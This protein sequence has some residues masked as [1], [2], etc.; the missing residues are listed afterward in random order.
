MSPKDF[1]SDRKRSRPMEKHGIT[2]VLKKNKLALSLLI[3][4][5]LVLVI[6]SVYFVFIEMNKE[7]DE[8]NNDGNSGDYGSSY[9]VAV[10]QTNMG[11]IKI[12][13]YPDKVNI[14]ANN[15]ITH[16]KNGYYDGLTFHRVI[17]DF[18]IQ[19]GDPNGD[20]TGGYAAEY[21]EGYGDPDQQSTWVIP[22]EF[23]ED[24]KNER[25][26]ISMANRGEN[27]GGS[28]FFILV[29]DSPHLDNKHAVFGKIIE[30]MDVVDAISEVDTDS[31]DKPKNPVVIS[32][33][34]IIE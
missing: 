28:Q 21:H 30:G 24:L 31:N 23:D 4:I 25:G 10:M 17:P 14:T 32:S 8:N 13:L 1:S 9:P 26:M 15:F 34:T 6:A 20:G 19:G 5:V 27:T 22:D 11:T 16:A 2:F 3:L 18:M 33:I 12:E 7:E 29:K